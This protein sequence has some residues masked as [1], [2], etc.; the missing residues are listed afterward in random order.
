VIAITL[1]HGQQVP[2]ALLAA[3]AHALQNGDI[4]MAIPHDRIDNDFGYHKATAETGPMHD[5]TR[6]K[7]AE[8]AHW[9]IDNIPEGR[10]Q[11]LCITSLEDAL[12]RANKA[13]ATTLSPLELPV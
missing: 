2:A 12:M 9:V 10:D 7:F 4:D 13:I 11:S 1:C 5:R 3:I 8:I 6:V